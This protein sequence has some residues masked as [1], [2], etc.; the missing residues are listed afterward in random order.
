[1]A[2]LV[3]LTRSADDSNGTEPPRILRD[4]DAHLTSNALAATYPLRARIIGYEYD[5][6]F[7][8]TVE[9]L[10]TDEIPFPLAAARADSQTAELVNDIANSAAQLANALNRLDGELR[11]AAGG[12][13]TPW[14]KGQL[15]GT[16]LVQVLDPNVRRILSGLQ[17]EPDRIDEA[18]LAWKSIAHRTTRE[19]GN[20]LLRTIPPE[21]FV[22]REVSSS[23]KTRTVRADT[24]DID[25]E[26]RIKQALSVFDDYADDPES[27]EQQ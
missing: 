13:P 23:G 7:S 18:G 12:D 26:W 17:A 8:S 1:M 14:D 6:Q 3:A 20:T 2:S 9:N 19:L 4:V 16:L 25:F 11:S 24:A 27:E 15:P 22:G 10:I 5:K 21:A